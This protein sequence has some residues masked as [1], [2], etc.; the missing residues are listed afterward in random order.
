MSTIKRWLLEQFYPAIA[1]VEIEK[2]KAE[3]EK[4]EQE[5]ERLNAYLDGL[6]AGIRSQRRVV[7]KNEVAK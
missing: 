7:I 3:L 6:E 5:I 1:K 4:K 2:L